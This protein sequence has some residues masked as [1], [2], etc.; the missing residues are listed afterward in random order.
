MK[1][2]LFLLAAC[3]ALAAA[4]YFPLNDA[5]FANDTLWNEYRFGI[6][7][8]ASGWV[9]VVGGENPRHPWPRDESVQ[10]AVHII[11]YCYMNQQTK[12][13]L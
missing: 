13:T 6:S 2:P 4:C 7:N 12:D 9:T 1:L 8:V 10:L 5:R 11:R 3:A